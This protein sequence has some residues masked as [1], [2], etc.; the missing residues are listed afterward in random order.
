MFGF[1]PSAS[2]IYGIGEG[3]S[4]GGY[5]EMLYQDRQGA[6]D[7]LDFLRAVIYFGAKLSPEWLF[8]SELEFEHATVSDNNDGS[9][10][11]APGSVSVEFAYLEYRPG[12]RTDFGVRS[13][14]LLVPMGFVNELHEPNVFLSANRPELERQIIPSTWRENGIGVFGET[15]NW[16]WRAYAIN[17]FDAAGFDAG[18]LRG[19][20]QS[21]G[22]TLADDFALVGRVD[23]QGTPGLLVGGSA[24]FGGAGQDNA[25]FGTTTTTLF[26][27]HIDW[28]PGS[29]RTRA[30]GVLG[31]VDDVEQ[32]NAAQGFVGDQSV[33]EDL[34][35]YYVEIGY[36]VMSHIAPESNQELVPFAR[37][38]RFDT[39]ASVPDG[40]T[41][42]PA[43]DRELLTVGV[44]WLPTPAVAIKADFVDAADENGNDLF[45]ISIGYAF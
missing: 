29:W 45:R 13:G 33:G 10:D 42:D 12:G 5:G 25:G 27:G 7:E 17:G 3:I 9:G 28:R 24:Y 20:R 14:L 23:Y 32:L 26:E 39:Q 1:A 38:E 6:S 19:G 35:G 40:F 44:S 36:D 30:L 15:D 21:G 31:S 2:K 11:E 16:N 43:N 34:E 18:G 4:L 41:R 8:N 37:Y 22:Q